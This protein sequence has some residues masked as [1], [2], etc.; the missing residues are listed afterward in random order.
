MGETD[1]CKSL[2]W[3][4]QQVQESCPWLTLLIL[5]KYDLVSDIKLGGVKCFTKHINK[6]LLGAA[7]EHD[8]AGCLLCP[9]YVAGS[10]ISA[11]DFSLHSLID[12]TG[13][14]TLFSLPITQ[15]YKLWT[16]LAGHEP[17]EGGLLA[18]RRIFH[19]THCNLEIRIWEGG[20]C[21]TSCRITCVKP[22]FTAA[23]RA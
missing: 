21:I 22:L 3:D 12:F 17:A 9:Q 18:V 23:L 7:G 11:V 13:V 2:K 16:W 20:I 19:V 10:N 5:E 1:G 4:K 15:S 8:P 6:V 14:L